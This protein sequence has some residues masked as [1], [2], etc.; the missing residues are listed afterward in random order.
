MDVYPLDPEHVI[1][2]EH[3]PDAD[4]PPGADKESAAYRLSV[5]SFRDEVEAY[6]RSI[7]KP[8]SLRM[9]GHRLYVLTDSEAL[10]YHQKRGDKAVTEIGKQGAK[11]RGL[12]QTKLTTEEQAAH[13]RAVAIAAMRYQAARSVTRAV[14]APEVP[15]NTG[16]IPRTLG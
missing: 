10:E 3:I 8:V 14:C 4:M 16:I 5:L 13:G 15:Q 9:H 6:M 2:G 12:D 1:K 7:G 11:L